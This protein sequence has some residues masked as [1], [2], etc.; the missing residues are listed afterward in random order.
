MNGCGDGT[1]A[2]FTVVATSVVSRGRSACLPATVEEEG[3]G[4][5]REGGDGGGIGKA[6]ERK[7][8]T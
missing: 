8:E 5:E 4:R 7:R 2:P 6:L 3:G 1:E